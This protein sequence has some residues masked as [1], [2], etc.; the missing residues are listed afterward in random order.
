MRKRIEIDA[1]SQL[2]TADANLR[3]DQLEAWL[4]KRG[5]S[6]GRLPFR[7]WQ[8]QRHRQL[9]QQAT[10]RK[11]LETGSAGGTDGAGEIC[12][13]LEI[14][15]PHGRIQTKRVPGSA[16]GPDFKKIFIGSHGR[17]G[18][19]LSATLR[20]VRLPER[21][22]TVKARWVQPV[23]SRKFL[24]RLAASGIRCSSLQFQDRVA[25]SFQI[26]GMKGLVAAEVKTAKRMIRQSGGKWIDG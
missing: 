11:A 23:K 14:E 2:V 15:S 4:R 22:L 16:T 9:R 7:N 1:V 12:L 5:Y 21:R 20:I 6:L 17:Y 25:L 10:L 26:E 24:K 19:I 18:K 3:L 13:S 8:R